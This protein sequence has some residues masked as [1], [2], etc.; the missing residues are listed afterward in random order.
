MIRSTLAKQLF[1]TMD[2]IPQ[3]DINIAVNLLIR[4][5]RKAICEKRTI[6]I[7]GFGTFSLRCHPARKTRNPKTGAIFIKEKN[8]LPHFKAGKILQEKINHP[9]NIVQLS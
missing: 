3:T 7:R 8:Y 4:T 2:N 9:S 5:M 1:Q 6:A